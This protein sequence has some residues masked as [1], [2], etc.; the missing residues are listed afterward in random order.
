MRI[1]ADL[2]IHS[3]YSRATSKDMNVPNI[4]KW[5]K[6]KGIDAVGSGDF[7]HPLWLEELKRYLKPAGDGAYVYDG[8]Y[9]ILTGEVSNIYSKKGQ[10]RKVHNLIFA[11]SFETAEKINKGI[12]RYGKILSDGRPILAMDSEDLV[13]TVLDISERC[14]VVPAHAWTPHFSVFGSNSGFDRLQDCYGREYRNIY[15]L[16]TGLSSDPSMNWRLSDLD[17]LTFISNSD[18]HSPRN[19]GREAN[20]FEITDRGNLYDEISGILKGKERGKFLY[21][22]EFFPEEGKYHYDGHRACGRRLTPKESIEAE[23]LCPGCGRKLTIGVLHRVEELA[24]REEGF[25][26]EGAVPFRNLIP[27]EEI[28]ADAVGLGRGTAK[29]EKEY[30]DLVRTMGSEFGILMDAPESD[31]YRNI[32]PKIAE[33]I[34]KVRAG[35]VD[36][37]PG[38]DGEFGSISIRWAVP[39]LKK[40]VGQLNLF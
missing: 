18:A 19:M 14:M 37:T 39:G 31:L 40:A 26:P 16:E 22:I 27:L 29:V 10:T 34:M 6:L 20:V 35:E 12:S 25:R 3:K 38:Y 7:T 1:I 24:D 36:V 13:K 30:L 4:A 11:P 8:T 15:S 28:I 33:G 32:S 2:H 23:G 17:G 21:T 9:F 5:A